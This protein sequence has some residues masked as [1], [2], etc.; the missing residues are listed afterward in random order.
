MAR[1]RALT[2][3]D[4]RQLVALVDGGVRQELAG[5]V[6]GVSRRTVVR[7]LARRRAAQRELTLEEILEPFR[8]DR[9]EPVDVF[10]EPARRRQARLRSRG[11]Q[12]AA[13]QLERL[14]ADRLELDADT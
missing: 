9:L 12:A 3:D 1:H 2:A 11:W 7:V 5:A 4:E 13:A 6:L 8:G 10:A 14:D